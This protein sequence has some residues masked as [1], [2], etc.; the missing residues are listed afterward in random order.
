ME[1]KKSLPVPA[2]KA[3]IKQKE[4]PKAVAVKKAPDE[5][6]AK[7]IRDMMQKEKNNLAF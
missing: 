3:E 5:V 7:A 6:I 4:N 2:L 1:N